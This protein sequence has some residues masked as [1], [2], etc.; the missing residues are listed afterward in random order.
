MVGVVDGAARG[1]DGEYPTLVWVKFH[2]PVS[3]PL[4]DV[5][6]VLLQLETVF[7]SRDG[8]LDNT[9]IRKQSNG[10]VLS[11]TWKVI[12]IYEK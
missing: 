4:S 12:N 2:Q 11:S 10:A 6:N 9:V 1:W 8:L 3:L 5:V 7:L